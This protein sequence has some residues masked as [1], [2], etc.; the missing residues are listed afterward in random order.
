MK[1]YKM[2]NTIYTVSECTINEIPSHIEKVFSYWTDTNIDENKEYMEIEVRE[3]TTAKITDEE[4]NLCACTYFLRLTPNTARVT[5]LWFSRKPYAA[6]LMD[7]VR[8]EMNLNK[9]EF[10]P[11]TTV[12]D[13]PFKFGLNDSTIFRHNVTGSPLV[14][15]MH[16]TLMNK[17]YDAYFGTG[18]I[19]V[20]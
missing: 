18:K 17:L 6:M 14:C 8:T 7:Y 20:I 10:N 15:N 16:G 9:V 1:Q 3:G 5:L 12:D 4:G 13:V 19:E 11:H 2:S